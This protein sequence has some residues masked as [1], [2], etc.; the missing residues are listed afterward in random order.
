MNYYQILNISPTA[1]LKDIK[2]AYHKLALQYH[3][4]KNPNNKEAEE[5]FKKIAEAYQVLSDTDRREQYDNVST[6]R[7]F[8]FNRAQHFNPF[9]MFR[10][11]QTQNG[12]KFSFNQTSMPQ[13][14]S[15]TTSRHS[16]N[17]KQF[18]THFSSSTQTVYK[19]GKKFVTIIESRNGNT[20]KKVM[21]FDSKTNTQLT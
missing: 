13:R 6:Q 16:N 4:D 17:I 18:T 19:D 1:S 2:K 12:M 11:F 9:D 3:P 5:M 21:V 10:Q 20:T 8:V 7:P 14:T 15:Y